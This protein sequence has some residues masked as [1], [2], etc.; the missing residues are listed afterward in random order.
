M[1]GQ[2]KT[3]IRALLAQYECNPQHRFG[4]NFLVDLNLLHKLVA[5][6]QVSCGDVILEVGPGTGSLTDCLLAEGA[7]VVAVEIDRGFQRLLA[8]RYA[9]ES[10][11]RLL[12]GDVLETKTRLNPAIAQELD[13]VRAD[14]A[15]ST[16]L[17]ANLPYQVATPVILEL[18]VTRAEMKSMTVTVQEEVA[19]KFIA[20]RQR[21]DYG[22]LAILSQLTA[23]VEILARIPASAFWPA[24]KVSSAILQLRRVEDAGALP[25]G[26]LKPLARF[27]RN[28][29]AARRKTL[30]KI[31]K[32]WR[33]SGLEEALAEAEIASALRPEQLDPADWRRVFLAYAHRRSE[34]A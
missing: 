17:V 20:S 19:Q 8:E 33:D 21:G 7:R 5:F 29:F 11:F 23:E 10:R 30:R 1:A 2:T 18:L 28:I 14:D 3:E 32:D 25:F 16:K 6:A 34:D 26:L 4:Q 12:A 31:A 15:T 22:P 27:L 13:A 24:P 9:D